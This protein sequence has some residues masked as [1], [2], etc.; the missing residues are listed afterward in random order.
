MCKR[1]FAVL[2]A[3][4]LICS[5]AI[6]VHAEDSSITLYGF[7]FTVNDDGNA[8][9]H[10][11]DNRSTDVVI[12][13]T[14]LGA[15]VTEIDDYAFFGNTE[16]NSISFENCDGLKSIGTNA[17]YG[18]TG[19]KDIIIPASVTEIGFGA[20]QN[21]ASLETVSFGNAITTIPKQLFYN[22]ESLKS[23]V[24]PDSVESLGDRC[25]SGCT[26]LAEIEI[27]NSVTSIADNAF[28]GAENLVL[29]CNEGSY[30]ESY[31]ASN[32]NV[33]YNYVREYVLGD[34][35]LDGRFNIL[36]A[37][38]IQKYKIGQADIHVFR[39]RN[40]A[41]VNGDGKITIRDATLIQMKLARIITEF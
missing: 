39:G 23:V 13:K 19:I 22:C 5:A 3:V 8:V 41:D 7:S 9:I 40:Y 14:L 1:L 12:P 30:A 26:S 25:F 32:E 10:S 28:A 6:A 31:G 4:T 18:C 36:D 11:Y 15:E 34:A 20:F 27:P 29:Y 16:I 33:A 2:L 37:T 38:V 24:V 35:N 21:C 17:F